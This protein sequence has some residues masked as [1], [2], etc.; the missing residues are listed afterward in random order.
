MNLHIYGHLL[1]FMGIRNL[2]RD[3]LKNLLNKMK[4][5]TYFCLFLFPKPMRFLNSVW[6]FLHCF[7]ASPDANSTRK[8]KPMF[9]INNANDRRYWDSIDISG[10]NVICIHSFSNRTHT[11]LR[12]HPF[13]RTVFHSYTILSLRKRI[14]GNST[15][16][17]LIPQLIYPPVNVK[18]L[19]YSWNV[20]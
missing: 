15:L 11:Y 3:H 18:F 17:H 7:Y 8:R 1:L 19:T 13:L 20:Y 10:I 5:P 16:V 2:V 6:H 14:T 12:G 4:N 9:S